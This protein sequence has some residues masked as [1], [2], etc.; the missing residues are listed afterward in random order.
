[1][2][3]RSHLTVFRL[4]WLSLPVLPF[5]SC[6]HQVPPSGGPMDTEG[7]VVVYSYPA[8]FSLF[9][10]TDRIEIGFDEYVDKRSVEESIFISPPIDDVEFEWA[11]KSVEI[12]F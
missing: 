2:I 1:M 10:T 5:F 12:V 6:A 3:P 9:V 7:P 11:G 4:S 8:Q